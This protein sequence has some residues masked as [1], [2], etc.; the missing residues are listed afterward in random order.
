VERQLHED[1]EAVHRELEQTRG[2]WFRVKR[3][4]VHTADRNTAAAWG[5]AVYRR[6]RGRSSRSA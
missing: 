4:L 1:L 3:R 2:L 5:L 6:A